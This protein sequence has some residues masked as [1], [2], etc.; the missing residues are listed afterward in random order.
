MGRSPGYCN[1]SPNRFHDIISFR[2]QLRYTVL[3]YHGGGVRTVR[4]VSPS[5][6]RTHTRLA[7]LAVVVV[8][9]CSSAMHVQV[10]ALCRYHARRIIALQ[11]RSFHMSARRWGHR[12]SSGPL[13]WRFSR[14][15]STFQHGHWMQP[16][17]DKERSYSRTC[18]NSRSTA[19]STPS[20]DDND[21]DA[22]S[23][24]GDIETT[25]ANVLSH[26]GKC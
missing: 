21:N 14:R 10:Q 1:I 13:A 19:A 26:Y 6:E 17:C 23:F 3:I 9:L 7:L 16:R 25:V 12:L 15:S 20:N 8:V 2:Y 4:C 18:R 22:R 24:L 5:P 11:E